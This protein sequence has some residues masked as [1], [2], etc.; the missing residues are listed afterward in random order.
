MKNNFSITLNSRGRVTFLGNLIQNIEQTTKFL[1]KIEILIR[2][3]S[4]DTESV[5]FSKQVRK[6][7][8]KFFIEDRPVSLNKCLTFLANQANAEYIFQINDDIKILTQDWDEIVLKKIKEYKDL[9]NI[10]DGV[11]YLAA[12]DN[13]I[14]KPAGA[15]YASFPI[16]SKEAMEVIGIWN[17][18]EFVGL[19][20]DS[21]IYR[22]YEAINR[23]IFAPEIKIDHIYHN[24]IFSI[25]SPD[26]TAYEMRAN[27]RRENLNPFTF[28]IS[29]EVEKLF[30]YIKL[31]NE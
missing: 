22:V 24:N 12:E 6:P 21:S 13:S 30:Q 8:V 27:S 16:I 26:L 4:D 3:D 19:G 11:I 29:K 7:Y 18:E 15:K 9:N 20:G 10:K 5:N 28:D 23:V 17:Y 31:K 14:D 2:I 1:D 25:M